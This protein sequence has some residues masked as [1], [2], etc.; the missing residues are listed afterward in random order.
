MDGRP[1]EDR[2]SA[3]A[4]I[5]GL[6]RYL[7]ENDWFYRN[8]EGVR[9]IHGITHLARVLFWAD[10][11]A[12]LTDEP[13]MLEEL[14]WAAANHDIMRENDGRDPEHGKRSGRWLRDNLT[15]LRPETSSLDIEAIR[16]LCQCHDSKRDEDR[17]PTRELAILRDADALDRMR[18]SH[19][20]RTDAAYLRCPE[21][22]LLIGVAEDFAWKRGRPETPAI[23]EILQIGEE[24]IR[25]LALQRL[26]EARGQS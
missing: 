17:A 22:A 25:P 2:E 3:E 14:R 13:L 10:F 20:G 16:L 23:E 6:A 24:M 5:E 1:G 21:S 11:L 19:H 4:G 12:S 9:S 8:P 18:F 26:E 7:P 15:S